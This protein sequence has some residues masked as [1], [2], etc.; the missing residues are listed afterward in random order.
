MKH[1]VS[2]N[3]DVYLLQAQHWIHVVDGIHVSL[4]CSPSKYSYIN[5]SSS[6]VSS[7]IFREQEHIQKCQFNGDVF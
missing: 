7:S 6:N 4:A 3:D 2:G 1:K 5:C